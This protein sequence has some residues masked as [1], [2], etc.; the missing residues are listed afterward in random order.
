MAELQRYSV[1]VLNSK[2]GA[3]KTTVAT[4]LA[5]L[6]AQRETVLLADLDPQGS[7][8]HWWRRRPPALPEITLVSDPQ[9]KFRDYPPAQWLILDAPAGLKRT[10]LEEMLDEVSTLLVPI[11]ASVLDM[12]AS[13]VFLERLQEIK[14]FRKGR[15]RI[16]I[17][18][19]RVHQGTRAK[20]AL[21]D[22]LRDLEI[23]VI[24]S[25]R[26][27]QI[28]VRAAAAGLGIADLRASENRSELPQWTRI[29]Q[30]L[31]ETDRGT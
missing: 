22:F 15:I 12:D 20:Q 5:S 25:L 23:P 28:Y 9:R 16:G 3:G 13:L 26:D 21:E 6:L 31:G 1:L 18:A 4:N 29:L 17:V 24:A 8:S 19:N 11:T 2:G 10:R 7:S 27:S 30:F 14:R